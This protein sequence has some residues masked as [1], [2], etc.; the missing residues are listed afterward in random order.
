[1]VVV[2]DDSTVASAR[3]GQS[4]GYKK[5]FDYSKNNVFFLQVK[6]QYQVVYL[7]KYYY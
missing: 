1:L 3:L 2:A 4:L 7:S 5:K 6:V